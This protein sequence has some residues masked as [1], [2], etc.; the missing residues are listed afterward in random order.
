MK[1]FDFMGYCSDREKY[2]SNVCHT[3][4]TVSLFI[5][6]L[7][8]FHTGFDATRKCLMIGKNEIE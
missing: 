3:F 6:C 4:R 7:T 8:L 5:L 1:F 2:I